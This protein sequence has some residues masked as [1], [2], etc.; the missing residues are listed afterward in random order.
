M[1]INTRISAVVIALGAALSGAAVAA[2]T[3]VYIGGS[4]GQARPNFD[5]AGGAANT[6]GGVNS[7]DGAYKFFAGYQFHKNF[8]VEGTYV[9]LGSFTSVSGNA[10]E[11]TGWGLSLVGMMPL[12]NNI[13]LLGRLG[14]YKMRQ[15]MKPTSISESSWSPA[16]GIGL[17][18]DFNQNFN[19][20]AEFERIQKIGSN[21]TTVSNDT[22][23]YTLGLGYRF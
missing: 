23:L 12:G 18:Y 5:T 20:R 10:F 17:Q 8:S 13:S 11:P 6:G 22:N 7:S 16:F 21:A 1:S 14:E 4:W 19:A 9:N 3:P 2:E 15:R